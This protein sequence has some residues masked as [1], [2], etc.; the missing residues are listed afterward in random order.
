MRISHCRNGRLLVR[1]YDKPDAF[2]V[3]SPLHAMPGMAVLPP[4]PKIT[5]VQVFLTKDGGYGDGIIAVGVL[6]VGVIVR[7]YVHVLQSGVWNVVQRSR[8][9]R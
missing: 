7:A 2:A 5:E 3:L 1:F 6:S 4:P 8:A 9:P